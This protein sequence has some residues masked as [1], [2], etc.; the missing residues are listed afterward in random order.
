MIIENK[1]SDFTII[2][3]NDS[4]DYSVS[5]QWHDKP[6]TWALEERHISRL[7]YLNLT[8]TDEKRVLSGLKAYE[9]SVLSALYKRTRR[10]YVLKE[11]A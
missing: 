7:K 9:R 1:F 3:D 10:K 8:S 6:Y 5:I 11:R 2:Y 4:K